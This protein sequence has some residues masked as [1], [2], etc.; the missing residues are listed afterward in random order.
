MTNKDLIL[1][2]LF[3]KY[4]EQNHAQLP[5]IHH[6]EYLKKFVLANNFESAIPKNDSMNFHCHRVHLDPTYIRQFWLTYHINVQFDFE[7]EKWMYP[8][9]ET[10]FQFLCL[11]SDSGY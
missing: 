5:E 10:R 6:Y 3:Q 2:M 7:T 8:T 4:C 1:I 9:G 11:C